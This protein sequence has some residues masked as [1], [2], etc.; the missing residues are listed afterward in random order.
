MS[1]LLPLRPSMILLTTILL[2]ACAAPT[3][4]GGPWTVTPAA[5]TRY[6]NISINLAL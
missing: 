3:A 4:D 1:H 5:P 2:T 6:I